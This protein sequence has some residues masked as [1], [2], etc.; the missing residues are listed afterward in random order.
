MTIDLLVHGVMHCNC[1]HHQMSGLCFYS[2]SSLILQLTGDD[3]DNLAVS[4]SWL[5][6]YIKYVAIGVV[7][8]TCSNSASYNENIGRF[9]TQ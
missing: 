9:Q 1:V 3:N 8:N 4:F 2:I 7:L 6:Q 5:P